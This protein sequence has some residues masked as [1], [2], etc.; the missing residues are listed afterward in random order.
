RLRDEFQAHCAGLA[1]SGGSG[2]W[3][4]LDAALVVPLI[5]ASVRRRLLQGAGSSPAAGTLAGPP[6]AAPPPPPSR[7]TH[8]GSYARE[9]TERAYLAEKERKDRREE[10]AEVES[11]AE[12]PSVPDPEF[13]RVALRLAR[14][15]GGLLEIGGASESDLARLSDAYES[16]RN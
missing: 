9:R 6:G 12:I 16:A 1:A 5:E 3:R 4:E 13:W 11:T 15:E 8:F 14:L 2:R 10:V 7:A